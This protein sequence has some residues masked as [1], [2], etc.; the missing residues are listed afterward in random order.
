MGPLGSS[1]T[2]MNAA[3]DELFD[4][5]K[6]YGRISGLESTG[7]GIRIMHSAHRKRRIVLA[8]PSSTPSADYL[9]ALSRDGLSTRHRHHAR[10]LSA[11]ERLPHFETLA[12]RQQTLPTGNRLAPFYA[13]SNLVRSVF[14]KPHAP[15]SRKLMRLGN[16]FGDKRV[17]LEPLHQKSQS[18]GG[19]RRRLPYCYDPKT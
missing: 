7:E 9:S 11:R 8:R 19:R 10:V 1:L 6:Y 3:I 16:S 13:T 4:P 15:Q 14:E 2:V 17:A 12:R 18:K 5:K